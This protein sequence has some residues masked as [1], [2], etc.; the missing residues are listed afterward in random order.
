MK[1]K[2]QLDKSGLTITEFLQPGDS[3]DEEIVDYFI[4]VLPPETMNSSV[5]QIGE[6]CSHD[7]HTGEALFMTLTRL[8]QHDPWVYAG[9]MPKPNGAE[10]DRTLTP[11]IRRINNNALPS[12]RF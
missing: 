10:G 12:H 5:I 9:I 6:P 11:D 2:E 1:T 7:H 3:V 8:S 4:G